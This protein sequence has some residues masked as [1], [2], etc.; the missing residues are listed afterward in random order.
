MHRRPADAV[1]R[2]PARSGLPWIFAADGA[3]YFV[4]EHGRDFTPVGQNDAIS[5]VEFQGLYRRRDLP[6][7]ERHLRWLLDHGV[8]VLRLMLEYA[9]VRTRYFERPAGRFNPHMVQLWDDLFAMCERLGLRILLT[10]FD[11]FWTWLHWAHHPYNSANG[12][13]LAH[14]SRLLLCPETRE[15]IRRRLRFAAT[16]WGGSGALFAWDLW[17]EIHPAQAEDSA[18]VFPDFISDLSR[19]VRHAELDLYGRA[20]PQTVSLFGPELE[21]K[22]HLDLTTPIFRHPALDFASLHIYAH[23]AIDDP[24]NTVEGAVAMGRIVR[25]ALEEITDQRPFLDTEHGPIH[26]FKDRKKTLPEA[27]DDEYFRHTQW[28]H[29]ASGGAG[30]GMRWPN[31]RPHTLT[32]GMRRAQRAMAGFLPLIKWRRLRRRN[33]NTEIVT[34]HRAVATFGCGDEDQAVVWLMRRAPLSKD[35]SLDANAAP[36]RTLVSV[37]GL[38]PGRCRI[39]PWDT[40]SGAPGPE[41]LAVSDGQ[42]L[43]FEAPPFATDIALAI[44]RER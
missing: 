22:P 29:L 4:D 23:G 3:P 39:T 17:N 34:S 37:P 6:A 8:T 42:A 9:Q 18:D 43:R 41:L 1:E 28:A 7:V 11:T 26:T 24:R 38:A 10:P 40:K 27:F 14:P 31:R 19:T 32:P 16:R 15:L 13:P 30:G 25:Q 35:G 33:L 44:R 5:W 21:L 20:H 2:T 36:I 12:G